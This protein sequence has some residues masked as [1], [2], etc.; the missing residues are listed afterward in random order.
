LSP[1]AVSALAGEF[2]AWAAPETGIRDRLAQYGAAGEVLEADIAKV[3][4]CMAE[5]ARRADDH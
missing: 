4:Q 3:L 5:E 1:K 2:A